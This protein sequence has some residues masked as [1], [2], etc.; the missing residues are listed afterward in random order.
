MVPHVRPR[1][2]TCQV[3]IYQKKFALVQAH[4]FVLTVECSSTIDLSSFPSS[5]LFVVI[6]KFCRVA[7]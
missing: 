3:I 4:Y 6:G 1:K 5:M 7:L 2:L